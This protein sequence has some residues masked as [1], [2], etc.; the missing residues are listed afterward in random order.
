MSI[1][2]YFESIKLGV[3]FLYVLLAM[4]IW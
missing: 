2:P 1:I 3:L 4:S